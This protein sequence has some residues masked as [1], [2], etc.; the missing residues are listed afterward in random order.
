MWVKRSRRIKNIS[1]LSISR[2]LLDF[3][4]LFATPF[5]MKAIHTWE[6]NLPVHIYCILPVKVVD[7]TIRESIRS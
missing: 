6:G 2:I 5:H 1:Y 4:L 3:Q 7:M